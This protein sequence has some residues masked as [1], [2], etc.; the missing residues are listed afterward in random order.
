MK[1]FLLR[2]ALF[3]LI[4]FIID[5]LFYVLLYNAPKLEADNRLEL[6]L[7]GKINKEVIIMGSSRGAYNII[8]G[9]IEKETGKT[10]YN[11][12]YAGSNIQFQLFL[13]KTL[14]R[15]NNAPKIII[16]S[17]DN[18]YEFLDVKSLEYRFDRLYPLEKYNYIN[19]ELIR[20]N[21]KS[22][23]LRFLYLGRINRSSF[24]FTKKKMPIES[25][26]LPCGSMPFAV[27]AGK[28]N[29]K[30]EK[31]QER[32]PIEKELKDKREAFLEFQKICKE[33]NIKLMYCFAPNFRVYN[34][35][36]ANRIK[37][38]S[39]PENLL[40]VYDTTDLRY[41]KIEY[42]HDESHLNIEG[43]KLFSNELSK[44]INLGKN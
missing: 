6:L 43:A 22:E 18:P 10:A 19:D 17:I 42:F 37:S 27:E 33:K 24:T 29:F 35:V 39:L 3:C 15:Y 40:Y 28:N 36:L 38:I 2:V 14:L 34:S 13:L 8:A 30:F 4:F 41:K 32:Y 5:K 20:Q 12:S 21:D 31:K 16:L 25:P 26:I 23:L 11:I 44:F 9:Q 1:R 7:N